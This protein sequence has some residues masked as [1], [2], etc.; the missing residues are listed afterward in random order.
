M[1][2]DPYYIH[3]DGKTQLH[4]ACKDENIAL[5]KELL[6]LRV[7]LN[8]QDIDGNT[9]LH[10][11]K[12][13]EIIKMLVEAGA[14]PN[15]QN[16]RSGYTPLLHSMVWWHTEKYNLLVPISDLNIKSSFGL[17]ALMLA[18][19]IHSLDDIKLLID[20]GADLYIRNFEGMD[21]YDLLLYDE[22]E[23]IIT[24]FPEFLTERELRLDQTSI[25][26]LA[27]RIH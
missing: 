24:Q 25:N 18:S 19:I 23:N 17:T 8:K 22:K 10:L 6:S 26:A 13:I 2:A 3:Y 12:N 16:Y 20:A 5:V 7:D 11:A 14:N 21:F 1:I 27:R 9:A 15:R 4:L